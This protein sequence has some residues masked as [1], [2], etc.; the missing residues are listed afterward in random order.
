SQC[1][2]LVFLNIIEILAATDV[3]V[4]DHSIL[5]TAL[6]LLLRAIGNLLFGSLGVFVGINTA[7]E[8]RGTLVLGGIAGLIINAPV[9]SDIGSLSIFGLDLQV[10][11]GLVGLL[12]VIMAVYFVAKFE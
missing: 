12:G 8:F 7:R 1:L 5:D 6:F 2:I 4:L 10:S 11:R 3:C 9:L